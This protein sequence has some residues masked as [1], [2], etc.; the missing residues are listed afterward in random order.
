MSMPNTNQQSSYYVGQ[1][2]RLDPVGETT[3]QLPPKSPLPRR[4]QPL[5][6]IGEVQTLQLQPNAGVS[7]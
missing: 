7:Q 4:L 6:P 5:P 1:H 3:V 2:R